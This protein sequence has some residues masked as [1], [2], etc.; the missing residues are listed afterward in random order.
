M[1]SALLLLLIACAIILPGIFILSSVGRETIS[2]ANG[3]A[4]AAV[5]D[6]T[7][8]YGPDTAALEAQAE[9]QAE[10]TILGLADGTDQVRAMKEAGKTTN[11]DTVEANGDRQVVKTFAKDD[12]IYVSGDYRTGFEFTYK[13]ISETITVIENGKV[14]STETTQKPDKVEKFTYTPEQVAVLDAGVAGQI[15]TYLDSHRGDDIHIGY[16]P[17]ATFGGADCPEGGCVMVFMQ[18]FDDPHNLDNIIK[19]LVNPET[20]TVEWRFD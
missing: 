2:L 14:L 13:D 9:E 3:P 17:G 18:N 6:T 8:E 1:K 4:R 7:E 12:H 16:V 19:V 20:L 11:T 5:F 10:N 15:Q